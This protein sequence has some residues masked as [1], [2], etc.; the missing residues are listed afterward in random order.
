MSA[1]IN[2][3]VK[4]VIVR[5]AMADMLPHGLAGWLLRRLRLVEV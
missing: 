5:L 4:A 3:M 2:R 1:P